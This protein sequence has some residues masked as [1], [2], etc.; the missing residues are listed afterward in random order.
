MNTF[1]ICAALVLES[2]ISVQGRVLD[3]K[4]VPISNAEVIYKRDLYV[5]LSAN[6]FED[7]GVSRGN[8]M[9]RASGQYVAHV[10]PGLYDV[11]VIASGYTAE[12]RKVEVTE[13]SRSFPTFHLNRD[14][15]ADQ[16]IR[17]MFSTRH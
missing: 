6:V 14:P 8:V 9:S 12:C 11:C 16:R 3:A 17:D 7:H 15:L 2:F 1:F 13:R 4:G 10:H 5:E